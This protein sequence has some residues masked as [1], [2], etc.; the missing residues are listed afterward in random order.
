VGT[1]ELPFQLPP[2]YRPMSFRLSGPGI[3]RTITVSSSRTTFVRIPVN[4]TSPVSFH[5]ETRHPTQIG[6]G[7]LVVVHGSAPRFVSA[8]G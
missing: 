8:N 6:D 4:A 5:L 7:R 2:G 3:A 1:L